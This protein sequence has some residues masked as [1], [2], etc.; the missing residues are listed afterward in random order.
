MEKYLVLYRQGPNPPAEAVDDLAAGSMEWVRGLMAE[1]K[2]ETTYLFPDGGGFAVFNADDHQ[3]LQRLIHGNPSSAFL[4]HEAHPLMDAI[5]GLE[6]LRQGFG[7]TLNLAESIVAQRATGATPQTPR[8]PSS[9]PSRSVS[10]PPS[11][12][13]T[14]QPSASAIYNLAVRIVDLVERIVGTRAGGPPP[15]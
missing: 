13:V 2:I 8:V 12:G 11:G 15:R 10:P 4:R 3:D 7:A 14:S 9:Q 1:G 6:G 5:P